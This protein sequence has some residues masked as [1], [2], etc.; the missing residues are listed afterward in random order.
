MNFG[1]LPATIVGPV[2]ETMIYAE[3]DQCPRGGYSYMLI[4]GSV[5]VEALKEA[6][7]RTQYAY[8]TLISVLREQRFGLKRLLLRV[9]VSDPPPLRVVDDFAQDMGGKTYRQIFYDYFEP[10]YVKRMDLF[11]EPPNFFYL[12]RF[13]ENRSAVVFFAHHISADASTTFGFVRTLFAAYHELVTGQAPDW[14]QTADMVSSNRRLQHYGT[15]NVLREMSRE[16]KRAKV[17]PVIRFGRDVAPTSSRRHLAGFDLSE[18]E[19]KAM[20]KKAKGLGVTVNDLLSVSCIRCIDETLDTPAGTLSFWVPANIR[21][22]PEDLKRSNYATAIN[23]DLIR[24]ERFDEKKLL[25]IFVAR[26]KAMF[27]SGRPFVSMNLLKK[28]LGFIHLFPVETRRPWMRKILNRPMTFMSSNVGVLWPKRV[29][30]KW[31]RYSEI[32]HAGGLDIVYYGYNFSTDG[33]LGHG[34]VSHTFNGCFSATF[35]VNKQIMEKRDG[36]EFMDKLKDKLLW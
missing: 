2:S 9:P 20:V 17:H 35:S 15:I 24:A 3:T 27:A 32:S 23:I 1:D 33:N 12:F 6:V 14:A 25:E 16:G 21:S 13:P 34:L 30:G 29:D 11:N 36:Q 28:L 7:R 8:P 18:E 26:R 4:E 22:T 10:K 31:T 5:D 19:T